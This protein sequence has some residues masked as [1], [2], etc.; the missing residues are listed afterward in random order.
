[1]I[2]VEAFCCVRKQSPYRQS[3]SRQHLVAVQVVLGSE[4]LALVRG[5]IDVDFLACRD[6]IPDEPRTGG[7]VLF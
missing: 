5:S 1:M 6:H 2:V 3:K 7:E 4:D